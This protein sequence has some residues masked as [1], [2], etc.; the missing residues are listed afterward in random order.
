M[1]VLGSSGYGIE[2][3]DRLRVFVRSPGDG[4]EQSTELSRARA[5]RT[6]IRRRLGDLVTP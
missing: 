5:R 6:R 1:T 3:L 2:E 4:S